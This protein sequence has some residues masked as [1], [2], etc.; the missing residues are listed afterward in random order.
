MV[1]DAE[2]DGYNMVEL[3]YYGMEMEYD[4]YFIVEFEYMGDVL[5]IFT[6]DSSVHFPGL[7]RKFLYPRTAENY[8]KRS[9]FYRQGCNYRIL[10]FN[11][12]TRQ[13][14]E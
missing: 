14:E 12:K 7:S 10:R 8:F 9:Y 6:F 13:V 11:H 1:T 5:Y 3:T 2:K 4:I